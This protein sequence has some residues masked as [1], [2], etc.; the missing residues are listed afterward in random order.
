M[1]SEAGCSLH[2][3]PPKL[4]PSDFC[5]LL[6]A[7]RPRPLSAPRALP[8]LEGGLSVV[9]LHVLA[10]PSVEENPSASLLGVMVSGQGKEEK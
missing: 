6:A 10:G 8:D 4:R 9:V 2:S 1:R 5:L 7:P 3:V